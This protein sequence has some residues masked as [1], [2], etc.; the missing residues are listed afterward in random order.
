MLAFVVPLKSPR[1]ARSWDYVSRLF[2][3][4]LRSICAQTSTEFRVIV[5][6][7][8]QPQIVFQHPAVAY[9]SVDFPV[10]DFND[11]KALNL[12]KYRKLAAG[13]T[14][15]R[16]IGASHAMGVDAD[17][18]V[19]K[20]LAEW[21]QQHPKS[22]G[23][24]FGSGYMYRDGSPRIY[25]KANDFYYWCG[26]SNIV[27]LDHLQLHERIDFESGPLLFGHAGMKDRLIGLGA[28]PATLPF[29]GA[30]YVQTKG[31]EANHHRGMLAWA[32]R[33]EPRWILHQLEQ[34]VI[35]LF[36]SER[37]TPEIVAEFGLYP[38]S[39]EIEDFSGG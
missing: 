16:E 21:V 27:R 12:D 22:P 39:P 30:V 36:R 1:V 15:A 14:A 29:P 34:R 31:G 32:L 38:L 24:F 8:D 23:W 9:L 37:L 33:N 7:H 26:T 35:Q 18:C 28:A 4:C 25:R 19:S 3:R 11:H 10:P 20:R 6:C 2:E 5:I 13:F 17:D